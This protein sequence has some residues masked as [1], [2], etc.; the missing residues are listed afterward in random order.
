MCEEVGRRKKKEENESH[1]NRRRAERGW[2][3]EGLPKKILFWTKRGRRD[4]CVKSGD[5]GHNTKFIRLFPPTSPREV[6]D[7]F[8]DT[9]RG[10]MISQG[11]VVTYGL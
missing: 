1:E 7:D 2:W 9:R 6:F 5:W 10:T 4:V 3:A 11:I 8:G